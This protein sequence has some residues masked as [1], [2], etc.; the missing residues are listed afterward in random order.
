MTNL[1]A[2]L[3]SSSQTINESVARHGG[4]AASGFHVFNEKTGE[5][6]TAWFSNQCHPPLDEHEMRLHLREYRIMPS[7]PRELLYKMRA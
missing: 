5:V 4:R 6:G 7:T 1:E 2:I 3:I